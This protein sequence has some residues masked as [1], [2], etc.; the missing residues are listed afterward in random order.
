MDTAKPT[1]KISVRNL[2]EFILRCGD[3]DSGFSGSNRAAEG[4]RIHR[5]IQKQ[6]KENYEIEVFVKQSVEKADFILIVDGRIDGVAEC[7]G[8]YCIDEI[9]S[10]TGFVKK[11]HENDYPLHWAQAQCYAYMFCIREGLSEIDIRLIYCEVESG[12]TRIFSRKYGID[13]LT[14]FF[15][16]LVAKYE[17]WVR[18]GLQW[19]IKRDD[20]L[21]KL[22]FPFGN[23]REGQRELAVAV[24]R[25]I[26]NKR[27]LF[28]KAPTGIG[29]TVSTI[30]PALKAMGEG[31]TS[32]IFYLTAK[33]IARSVAEETL[34]F[35]RK[36]QMHLKSVTLTAKD[37]ICFIEKTVCKP[38]ACEYAKGHYDRVN[39][40]LWEILHSGD[41]FKRT[42]VEEFA[43]KHRVCPFEL[44]L[45]LSLWCDVIIGD[46]N[47]V[48]D[49]HV[50]L[51]RFFSEVRTD[52]TFLVDEAHNLVERS[53]EMFSARIQR[54]SFLQGR[55]L[56][57][58]VHS[59]L[60]KYLGKVNS[61]IRALEKLV[62]SSGFHVSQEI[63]EKLITA[64]EV[65]TAE[66][67][68]YLIRN[69]KNDNEMILQL[70]FDAF[71]FLKIVEFFDSRYKFVIDTS[72]TDTSVKLFCIDPSFLMREA[73]KRGKASVFFSATLAPLE[74][75][76]EILGG[77]EDDQIITLLSPFDKSNRCILVAGDVSTKYQM[78]EQSIVILV[79]YLNNVIGNK[80]GNYM[81]FFPSY[82]YM[83]SVVSVLQEQ[84]PPFKI[85]TQ[86]SK[87]EEVKRE[88]FLDCFKP[89]PQETVVG[90]CVL[91]GVFSEGIDLKND[92]LI[93]SIIIG[94][95]L[96]QICTERDIIRNYFQEKRGS[97]FEY[98]YQY[99]GMNKVM[100]AAGRVIRSE[101][102]RGVIVLIDERY[103]TFTYRNLFPKEWFPCNLVTEH[104]INNHIQGFWKRNAMG[105]SD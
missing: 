56:F 29:K 64:L 15:D 27:N 20:S 81:V 45:D 71:I 68:R 52:Y 32:K 93:G 19:K 35:M 33:T 36:Q 40:C 16:A 61:R 14:L 55:R 3:I 72:S 31:L 50:Y 5:K 76:R 105:A 53:R 46:Y 6:Q 4:T 91:G 104:T 86:S 39:D 59:E 99:P 80:T 17:P 66:C 10:T 100:Q 42:T 2:V 24:Y 84:M 62:D 47:Y 75:Y 9:K 28:A 97:G 26:E 95:G 94:V 102:D 58:G 18:A 57:K 87:M 11:L 25:T 12:E 88:E 89:D 96:P 82:R 65:F 30:F 21:K 48:F 37:K 51:K 90:F 22:V 78:R 34:L 38:G 60:Y 44:S 43:G 7:D 83:N 49:P 79:N 67:E 74:Y 13:E 77:S 73:L 54:S 85:I 101:E 92:R 98:A 41:E 23:Y 63:D 1:V 70:Y 8:R 69:Q 103:A